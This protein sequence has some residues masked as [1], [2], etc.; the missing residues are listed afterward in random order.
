MRSY[1]RRTRMWGVTVASL[2]VLWFSLPA[3]AIPLE[4]WDD[5]IPNANQRFKVLPEF[6]GMAVLDKET[7][8]M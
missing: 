5:K 4:S 3:G 7:Q 8:L 1:G 6:G 2:C